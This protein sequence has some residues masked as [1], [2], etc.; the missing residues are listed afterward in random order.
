MAIGNSD[1]MDPSTRG[2]P[3][4]LWSVAWFCAGLVALGVPSARGA[5]RVRAMGESVRLDPTGTPETDFYAVL[6]TIVVDSQG[7]VGAFW[8]APRRDSSQETGVRGRWFSGALEP[9]DEDFLVNEQPHIPDSLTLIPPSAVAFRD[10]GYLVTWTKRNPDNA[11]YDNVWARRYS[12]SDVPLGDEFII[13]TIRP[14]SQF[15]PRL[16]S[17]DKSRWVA[18]WQQELFAEPDYSARIQL[19]DGD[20]PVDAEMSTS[21]QE[22]PVT[23]HIDVST[24]LDGS[25]RAVWSADTAGGNKLLFGSRVHET[26]P[27]LPVP[28]TTGDAVHFFPALTTMPNGSLLAVWRRESSDGSAGLFSRVFDSAFLPL[29][30]ETE[31]W[32]DISPKQRRDRRASVAVSPGGKHAI[33][34]WEMGDRLGDQADRDVAAQLLN[35][36]GAPVGDRFYLTE[37]I[38]GIDQLGPTVAYLSDNEFVV[39]WSSNSDHEH[40]DTWHILG[41]RFEVGSLVLVCGDSNDDGFVLASDGLAA[42]QAAIGL[43]DCPP[44]LCD[45]NGSGAATAVDALAIL[46]SAVGLPVPLECP[47]CSEPR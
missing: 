30:A 20:S 5:T 43:R 23:R 26:E 38:Q 19:F 3:R 45:A 7:R 13:N 37:V 18:G 14:E 11:D 24:A 44:C 36:Q 17:A 2:L 22:Y 15:D 27:L 29:T 32:R 4:K 33:A 42:L 28:L 31:V 1:Q 35:A 9:I 12:A 21:A 40:S 8:G 10:G 39:T 41:R 46:Q 25:F 34:V 6:G 47:E 16:A